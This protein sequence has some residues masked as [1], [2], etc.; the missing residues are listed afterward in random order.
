[1]NNQR[2]MSMAPLAMNR[3][4]TNSR[5]SPGRKKPSRM[6]HSAKMISMMPSTAQA[7]ML[8]I[9]FSGLSQ[10]GRSA[11]LVVTISKGTGAA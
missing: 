2:L 3:P 10:P 5:V 1:M 4:D 11:R 6:P 8:L 7:P 9:R